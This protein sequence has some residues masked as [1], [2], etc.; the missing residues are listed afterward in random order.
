MWG[1]LAQFF[2]VGAQIGIW[3][4]T[5]RYV[6]KEFDLENKQLPPE[7]T[8]ESYAARYYLAS[9]VLFLASR[10][11]C[12]ILMKY[13]TPGHLLAFLA[14][15]AA[16]FTGLVIYVGGPTGIYALVGISGCMSLM[17]PTIFGLSTRGLGDDTKL[18]GAGHVMAIAGG[19]AFTQLQGVISDKTQNIN[20]S[21]WIPLLAFLFIAYYGAVL[22]RIDLSQEQAA[23]Q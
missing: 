13:I 12:T 21:F 10:F 1:V 4:Y 2:Y 9:I 16:G 18:S 11:I 19:A 5:I 8:P 6:M 15:I 22:C 3:S 23:T 17:F 14:L 20:I 7:M